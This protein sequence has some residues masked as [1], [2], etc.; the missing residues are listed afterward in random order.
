MTIISIRPILAMLPALIGAGLIGLSGNKRPNLRESFSIISGVVKLLIVVSMVPAVL[1]GNSFEYTLVTLYKGIEIKFRADALAL[2]FASTASFLWI[3]TSLYSIGYMRSTKEHAQ[4]RYF[5]CFAITLFATMGAAFSANLL[6]LYIFYEIITMVT[7][8]LVTHKETPEALH[9]GRKYITYL[10]GTSKAFLLP[11]LVLTYTIAGTLEFSKAGIFPPGAD[12]VI[13]TVVFFLFIAGFAKAAI[14]PFHNW[15]PAAMVAPTPVSA[16]LHAVAVVKVG[17]FSII[18]VVMFVFGVGSMG[19]LG[20]GLPLAYI[21]CFTI[22]VASIIALTKDNLKARLAYSTVS[23]L[24]YIILG[25]ALLTPD[26]MLGGIM[27]IANHA[28][29]KITLFFCAGSIYVATH[30]TEISQLSGIGRRMPFTMGAFFIGTLSMIGVPLVAGFVSKW[31]IV[32]GSLQA[33][34]LPVLMAL[35][36]STVLNAAYFL[37]IVY[38]AFFEEYK[39]DH[40]EGHDEHHHGHNE[41]D[42]HGNDNGHHGG[43][44][45]GL[46][47]SPYFV[48]VPLLITAAISIALGLYP[49]YFMSLAKEVLR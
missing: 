46:R 22:V 2:L 5:T 32:L 17:V 37:P 12:K 1:G 9:G 35:L 49:D 36:A 25:A 45:K 27:H 19:A 30:R 14:M 29:S 39:E 28:F 6:T 41:H 33:R 24:S 15:L 11:A 31:Y 26:S 18:R 40:H 10:L 34:E 7:Y 43:G 48:V 4:T 47:E 16:L 21:A 20:L 13:L 3:I 42:S 38:K 8:P 23:Q 44:L